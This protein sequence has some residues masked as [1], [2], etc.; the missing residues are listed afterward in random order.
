LR[1]FKS[2]TKKYPTYYMTGNGGNK[3]M[4]FPDLDMVVV[5]TATNYNVRGAHE[6][7]DRLLT[8]FILA[9]VQQ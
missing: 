5:I 4:V 8:D 7:T 6:L 3:A 1:S 9:A 2:G